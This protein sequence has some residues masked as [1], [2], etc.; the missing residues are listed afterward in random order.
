MKL[1]SI[2]ALFCFLWA[3]AIEL[4]AGTTSKDQKVYE[5]AS[6]T[7]LSW[8]DF[9]ASANHQ[10]IHRDLEHCIRHHNNLLAHDP[11]HK[12]SLLGSLWAALGVSYFK[13]LP[14]T[15]AGDI[16]NSIAKHCAE[17]YVLN[18]GSVHE[19]Q[20]RNAQFLENAPFAQQQVLSK[21]IMKKSPHSH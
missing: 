7:L 4:V 20:H 21:F 11:R 2:I 3:A 12:N 1:L 18:A 6:H 13:P 15:V 10:S 8:V 5:K 16:A 9:N 19:A 14:E 17:D